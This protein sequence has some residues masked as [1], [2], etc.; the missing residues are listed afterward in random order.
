MCVRAC[1]WGC[2]CEC[3]YVFMY[4]I[5][6]KD[7]FFKQMLRCEDRLVHMGPKG[8]VFGLGLRF[9]TKV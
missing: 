9:R 2:L 8:A 3:V 6:S 1:V 5:Q 4:L 7:H